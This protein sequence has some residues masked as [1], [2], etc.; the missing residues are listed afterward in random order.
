MLKTSFFGKNARAITLL[1]HSVILIILF[2]LFLN[3]SYSLSTTILAILSSNSALITLIASATLIFR[4]YSEDKTS[5][6]ILS[7]GFF[8][9]TIIEFFH[10]LIL[11]G[12]LNPFIRNA[13]S[14]QNWSWFISQLFFSVFILIS[15]ISEKISV[16]GLHPEKYKKVHLYIIILCL[17]IATSFLALHLP[18]FHN[19]RY[20][21]MF[22]PAAIFLFNSGYLFHTK[23]WKKNIFEFWLLYTMINAFIYQALFIPFSETLFDIKYFIAQ[24]LKGFTYSGVL[25]G[26]ASY[27]YKNLQDYENQ[28]QRLKLEKIDRMHAEKV[29]RS[30]RSYNE[31]ILRSTAEGILGLDLNGKHIFVNP[32][33]EKI[34]GYSA[35]ELIGKSSHLTWHRMKPDGTV[36]PQKE[37]VIFNA[38][39]LNREIAKGEDIFWTKDGKKLF[40][41]YVVSPLLRENENIGTV[42]LFSDISKSKQHEDELRKKSHV[43]DQSPLSVVITN[44]SGDIEYVNPGFTKNS[45][46]LPEE[47]IGKNPRLLNAGVIGITDFKD[48]WHKLLNGKTWHGELL[49]RKKNGSLVWEDAIISPIK[50]SAGQNTHYVAIKNDISEQKK[51]VQNLYD[52]QVNLEKAQKIAKL[53]SWEW[54]IAL[55]IINITHTA[56]EK[57]NFKK[58]KNHNALKKLIKRIIDIND[59]ENLIRF[60]SQVMLGEKIDAFEFKIRK[61]DGSFAWIRS[62]PVEIKTYSSEKKPLTMVGAFQDITES[63]SIQIQ[64]KKYN[65]ALEQS[66][67]E[68]Q[69]FAFIASHDLQEPLRKVATFAE[70]IEKNSP[71]LN[72]AGKESLWRMQKALERMRTLLNDL[73]AYSRLSTTQNKYVLFA[74]EDIVKDVIQYFDA[75][76]KKNGIRIKTGRLNSIYADPAKIRMLLHNL[77]SNAIKYQKTDEQTVI[78]IS[79]SIE[80]AQTGTKN[81]CT[82]IIKDNGIG[83][84]EKYLNKIFIPFQRLHSRTEYEGTGIGLAICKKIVET[85][86]GTISAKSE[87]AKGASFIVS[88]PTD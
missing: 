76:I 37:C 80:K 9:L 29:L 31:L 53:R 34:L 7:I 59:Q 56:D 58:I 16:S 71:N 38:L 2:V 14:V 1:I 88:I 32:A 64:L 10:T 11:S 51:L 73:L 46:Y 85:H 20:L 25:F 30:Y 48:M 12:A 66:N 50:D 26:L 68:L 86:G 49:N 15:I 84:D 42:V 62:L 83:F 87:P 41:D 77:L 54:N 40:V 19:Q 8:G 81:I 79:S 69:E 55:D 18:E 24:I 75:P 6:L 3:S 44:L 23:N 13:V 74:L 35:E 43:I 22:I 67:K 27:F 36:Y 5:D 52:K 70:R 82:I 45:G 61:Q 33:G 39:A 65:E 63:K 47:V 72:I 60:A 21:L 28:K 4:Y 17:I 78:E 57:S